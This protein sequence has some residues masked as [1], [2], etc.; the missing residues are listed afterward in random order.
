MVYVKTVIDWIDSNPDQFDTGRIYVEGFSQNAAFANKISFCM[1]EKITGGWFQ[2]ATGLCASKETQFNNVWPCYSE[3]GPVI[4]CTGVYLNDYL[5]KNVTDGYECALKE[6][7]EQRRFEFGIK[8]KGSNFK[9]D[10]K[11][12]GSKDKTIPG[13]HKNIENR[14]HWAAGC[15]GLTLPCSASCEQIFDD[16]MTSEDTS[17][18]SKSVKSFRRCIMRLDEECSTCSPTLNM[19][20]QSEEPTSMRFEHFGAIDPAET[21]ERP[22]KSQCVVPKIF[23]T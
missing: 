21:H 19:L 8:G 5:W 6:G 2:S 10:K 14:L 9:G 7:H 12:F 16:C 18:T 4:V 3:K 17:T 15:W 22:K 23:N 20:M 1:S 11:G 13:G